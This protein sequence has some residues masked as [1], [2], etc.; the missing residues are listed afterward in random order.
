MVTISNRNQP[1]SQMV[2]D[3]FLVGVSKTTIA[4]LPG[5]LRLSQANPLTSHV[6]PDIVPDGWRLG[7][8]SIGRF[9][10]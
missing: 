1:N 2:A 3:G 10:I 6:M 5:S 4:I 7:S 8:A 9:R